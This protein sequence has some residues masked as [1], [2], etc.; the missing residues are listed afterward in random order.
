[1]IEPTANA[2]RISTC[3][4]PGDG[5]VSS[6]YTQLLLI[7]PDFDNF[8]DDAKVALFDMIYNLGAGHNRRKRNHATGLRAYG[9]MNAAINRGDWAT[10]AAHC[11]RH[12]IPAER[13]RETAELFKG[14]AQ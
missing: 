9:T 5:H 14:C 4:A 12:G 13:N 2:A 11:L 8:P 7:Y 1:M 10:A 3:V 6:D